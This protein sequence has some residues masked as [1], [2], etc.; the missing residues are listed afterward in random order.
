MGLHGAAS[1]EGFQNYI[2]PLLASYVASFI[3]RSSA[4]LT[5]KTWLLLILTLIVYLLMSALAAGIHRLTLLDDGV[6]DAYEGVYVKLCTFVNMILGFMLPL[7]L[8]SLFTEALEF[9]PLVEWYELVAIAC[10]L[11]VVVVVML[12]D[13]LGETL[14]LFEV[15]AAESEEQRRQT[16]AGVVAV[17]GM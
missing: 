1:R 14:G 3:V 9:S 11:L 4:T 16:M 13:I 8:F 7:F 17:S 6:T 10:V 5:D 12:S 15:R 2:Q